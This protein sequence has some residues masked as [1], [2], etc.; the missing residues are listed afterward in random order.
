MRQ[1]TLLLLLI[2]LGWGIH[3]LR[4]QQPQV[5][6]WMDSQGL[7]AWGFADR[8]A[9]Y[10]NRPWQYESDRKDGDRRI[11]TLRHGDERLRAELRPTSDTTCTIAVDGGRPQ[12]YRR[13]DP[14]KG[15]LPYLPADDMPPAPC[16][17][18]ED[19]ATLRGF[20][21]QAAGQTLECTYNKAFIPQ[22]EMMTADI[23]SSG[24]FELHL[25][26][27]DLTPLALWTST[28][29][30]KVWLRPQ[31]ELFVYVH[32]GTALAMGA[33]SRLNNERWNTQGYQN[34]FPDKVSDS[35]CVRK[36]RQNL[37]YQQTQLDNTVRQYPCLSSAYRHLAEEEIFYTAL[38]TLFE[39][40]F[41]RAA[42]HPELSPE[43]LALA[44]SLMREMPDTPT[45]TSTFHW[46]FTNN[47]LYYY[48][49]QKFT[50]YLRRIRQALSEA[51][52]QQVPD[53]VMR[54]LDQVLEQDT[55]A[56]FHRQSSDLLQEL[57]QYV[58]TELFTIAFLKT[59]LETADTLPLPDKQKD[60]M[61]AMVT[62]QQIDNELLP[63]PEQAFREAIS[64]IQSPDLREAVS[65]R[66][67]T[68]H[69]TA[70]AD[71]DY[72]GSLRTNDI[73]A[74]LTDGEEILRRLLAPYRGKVVYTDIWGI[75]CMP[76]KRDMKLFAPAIKEALKGRDVVFLY[77]ANRSSDA[78]WK[79]IIKEYGCVGLQT[80]HYNLPAEQQEAVERILLNRGYPSYALF[81]KE[82]KLVTK[83]APRPSEKDRLVQ[84]IEEL[85]RQPN[86][87][88]T[89]P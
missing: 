32:D 18:R 59:L 40:Q 14:A 1:K 41:H 81:D 56:D 50:D 5:E 54:R 74:G 33:D 25:P 66:Q 79:Q 42:D 67:N 29:Y 26:L 85:L 7:W 77:L 10:G 80:V 13:W 11:L 75:W 70:S 52:N 38:W 4:A 3:Q 83:D 49:D 30:Q 76:C 2:L 46:S 82:G 19:S 45:M 89:Q 51:P 6:C 43:L 48:Y 88:A 73:V 53:S 15:I 28:G 58:E 60:Y 65:R 68:Y 62:I 8:F 84:A 64:H 12:T 31:N 63:L 27:T 71:F 47:S 22:Q 17:Y 24:Y 21:P 36:V 16:N 87:S 23:D 57:S 86:A 37:R 55:A 35:E 69:R 39:Q 78:S 61:R 72:Q 9:V 44:D 34:L 20:W